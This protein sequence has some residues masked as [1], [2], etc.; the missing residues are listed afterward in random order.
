MSKKTKISTQKKST[1]TTPPGNQRCRQLFLFPFGD[2]VEQTP[3]L[4]MGDAMQGRA[5]KGR[6]R[7]AP[8]KV[9]QTR[10]DARVHT[11]IYIH[12]HDGG[13]SG[14][15]K[16][17]KK[18]TEKTSQSCAC[19]RKGRIKAARVDCAT[20]QLRASFQCEERRAGCA[21][22]TTHRRRVAAA[23]HVVSSIRVLG[24]ATKR[25]CSALLRARTHTAG[26]QLCRLSK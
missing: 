13:G 7:A 21:G 8:F 11:H 2:V 26:H 17:E 22:F 9:G 24:C 3:L 6:D 1:A 19:G 14:G 10:G 20:S 23:A 25:A 15:V 18:P 4:L 12:T 16:G 5:G